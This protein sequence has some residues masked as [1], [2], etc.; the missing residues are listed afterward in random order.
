MGAKQQ[1]KCR[2]ILQI[3]SLVFWGVNLGKT[4]VTHPMVDEKLDN[5]D[6]HNP[7]LV[8][9]FFSTP[10]IKLKLGQQI[11]GRLLIAN[12]LDQSVWWANQKHWPAVKSYLLHSFL[13]VHNA[14]GPFTSHYCKLCI[15]LSQNHFPD[16]NRQHVLTF[17]HP[18]S[19]ELMLSTTGDALNPV[20]TSLYNQSSS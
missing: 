1:P 4:R 5:E 18:I 13:Q 2:I 12:H 14:T 17:L 16:P 6:D 7:S 3:K 15:M 20:G 11:G 8:S 9:Y 19:L 10:P